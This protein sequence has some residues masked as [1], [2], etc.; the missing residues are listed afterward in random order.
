MNKVQQRESH[1]DLR[2][3]PTAVNVISKYS[4]CA[5]RLLYF[6]SWPFVN[7]F[8]WTTLKFRKSFKQSQRAIHTTRFKSSLKN[9]YVI[10]LSWLFSIFLK[11]LILINLRPVLLSFVLQINQFRDFPRRIVVRVIY[12][13]IVLQQQ[14]NQ[15]KEK[16]FI[17]CEKLYLLLGKLVSC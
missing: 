8:Y 14:A 17:F 4:S 13:V 2:Q 16:L 15:N 3:T 7:K 5:K 11:N 12:Y 10:H 1:K 6:V 9:N